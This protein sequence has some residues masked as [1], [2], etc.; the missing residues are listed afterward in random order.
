MIFPATFKY[1]SILPKCLK[2]IR[3]AENL[4]ARIGF[5]FY[6]LFSS[7]RYFFFYFKH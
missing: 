6:R 3:K 2:M 7:F 1:P 4:M 5:A